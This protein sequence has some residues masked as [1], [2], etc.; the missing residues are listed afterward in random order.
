MS[1]ITKVIAYVDLDNDATHGGQ[2]GMNVSLAARLDDG[3]EV[4]GDVFGFA[5]PREGLG[6]IWHGYRGPMLHQDPAEHDRLL[7]D[8]Y[9]VGI[10]DVQDAINQML[11]RDPEMHRPPRLSWDGL[12]RALDDQGIRVSEQQLIDTPLEL[13]LS[14][15]AAAEVNADPPGPATIGIR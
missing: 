9:H 4:A 2:Y 14:A 7:A 12:Q 3:R 10:D 13:V 5:G 11:G 8:S 15:S 1:N 6:A